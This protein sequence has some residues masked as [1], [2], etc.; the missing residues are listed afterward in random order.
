MLRNLAALA[1]LLLAATGLG[2]GYVSGEVLV[3]FRAPFRVSKTMQSLGARVVQRLPEIDV[4][5]VELPAGISVEQ[6]VRMFGQDPKVE[7][8]EPN[9][10]LQ[11]QGVNDPMFPQQ[12]D[13]Q[14]ISAPSA[15]MI[16]MGSQNVL[17][18]VLDT[19]ADLSHPDLAGRI[20]GSKNF[21]GVGPVQDENGHGT[22]TAGTI[23]AATNNGIGVASL[24]YQTRLLVGKV[25]TDHGGTTVS[26]VAQGIAWAADNGA[27]VVS[28]SIGLPN[29]SNTL[30]AAVDDA[31]N[32]GLVLVAAAGNNANTQRLYPAAYSNCIAVAATDQADRRCSFSSYGDWVHV[33]A[34]GQSILSLYKH[35]GTATLNGTSMATP[36]V[37]ALAALLWANGARS[38]A[39]IRSAILNSGDPTTGF[40][41]Y[42]TRRI[43]ARRALLRLP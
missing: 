36:H 6:A 7:Y 3:K 17:V 27:K 28:M 21:I 24:G 14:K 8:A 4:S 42:P 26:V 2:Q 25:V 43:N 30:H 11:L 40:G 31:W 12:W 29:D 39:A 23:A 34:P 38:N 15:W 10:Y 19:G 32:R 1:I 41:L 33:S 35:G 22:H 13:L 9:Y 37:A 20:A 18:A 5:R 16:C